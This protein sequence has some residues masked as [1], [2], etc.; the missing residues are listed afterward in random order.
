MD[1]CTGY[2][3]YIRDL[4]YESTEILWKCTLNTGTEV[5]SDWE[6]DEF[7]EPNP[8]KRM[9]AY[10]EANPEE[11]IVKAE[12]LPMGHRPVLLFENETGLDGFFLLR[13]ASK[14]VSMGGGKANNFQHITA[15]LLRDDC[16]NIDVRKYS[17]PQCDFEPFVQER[18]LTHEN[19]VYM[20]WTNGSTKRQSEKVQECFDRANVLNGSVS[21]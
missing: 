8:Y 14:D 6:N 5:W 19:V 16:E 11:Y 10:L 21:S 13:G 7:E 2:N 20:V 18:E 3:K 17:F 9:M 12:I 15:G 4:I 1:I